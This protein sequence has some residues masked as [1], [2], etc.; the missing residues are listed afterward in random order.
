MQDLPKI[1]ARRL[2][3]PESGLA[4]HIS[5]NSM[6]SRQSSTS[7]A[8]KKLNVGLDLMGSTRASVCSQLEQHIQD[9]VKAAVKEMLSRVPV[10]KQPNTWPQ[11]I[12][13]SPKEEPNGWMKKEEQAQFEKPTQ[14]ERNLLQL[15]GMVGTELK[16]ETQTL[17]PTPESLTFSRSP[18]VSLAAVEQTL[19]EPSSLEQAPQKNGFY[20]L[21]NDNH[22]GNILEHIPGVT[23]FP[24]LDSLV[25]NTWEDLGDN[26]TS[27]AVPVHTSAGPNLSLNVSGPAGHQSQELLSAQGPEPESFALGPW[28]FSPAS[29]IQSVDSEYGTIIGPPTSNSFDDSGDLDD[30]FTES[31]I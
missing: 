2:T 23:S 3:A 12:V 7:Q 28:E 13:K 29:A 5:P 20:S 6:A 30:Q 31:F 22:S 25:S 10:S 21:F 9:A 4:E 14:L 1:V 19:P 8:G 16:P 15:P 18:E 24:E 17:Y 26:S 11:I 27:L